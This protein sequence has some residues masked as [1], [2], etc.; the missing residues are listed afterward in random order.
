MSELT[1]RLGDRSWYLS[2]EIL[3]FELEKPLAQEKYQ[4]W[5]NL[6]LIRAASPEEAYEKAMKHGFDSEDNVKID[7]QKGRCKF[8]GL[9]DLVRIYDDLEDGAELVWQEYELEKNQLEIAVKTKQDLHAFKSL[10][11]EEE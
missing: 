8:K 4:V 3:Y 11:A 6:I 10:P 5:E 2:Y 9:K 1:T 7:G